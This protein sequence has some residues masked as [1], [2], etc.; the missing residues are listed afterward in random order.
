MVQVSQDFAPPFKL[1]APYFII[2]AIFFLLS[3]FIPLSINLENLHYM[4]SSILAW[5]HILLL[6]FVMMIIFGAMAQLIPVTLEV[7]HFSVEFYYI[8]WPLLLIGTI[9]MSLGFFFYSALLPYG[10]TIVLISMFIFLAE[11]FLTIKKVEK[12]NNVIK[13]LIVSNVFLFLGVIVGIVLALTYAGA[14][15]A[16]I[17]LLLK[18]HVFA[19]VAGYICITL[20]ALSLVLLPMFGLS[21]NFSQKPMNLAVIIMTIAVSLVFLS[22]VFNLAS[23]DYLGY[24][25]SMI[26]L[27]LF[28][29]EVYL[30][31]K[32]RAR[33]EI[34]IYVKSL[35][36]SFGSLF[37][38]IFLTIAY[39]I[40]YYQPLILTIGWL[41]FMGFFAFI[42]SGHIYKI[43]P[44]LVW[45]EKFSP[46]VGKQKVPMLAD[47]LPDTASK[48]QFWFSLA[49]LVLSTLGLLFT[50]NDLFKAGA[51]FFIIGAIFLFKNLIYMIRYE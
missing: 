2:G 25:L 47:M 39:F 6:G 26:S 45:F 27:G 14:I 12:F 11:V 38:A 42:I 33:K 3:T 7:G 15:S 13:S 5:T 18:A 40:T 17:T 28:I 43:V 1:I 51:S 20:M 4:D 37:L 31:Y 8:I 46:L 34:D 32:T 35:F 48:F 44:F 10:G 36:V 30:I 9:L 16:D 19:V 41:M 22:G 29:Y 49:G 24:I 21:H 23:L 50:S